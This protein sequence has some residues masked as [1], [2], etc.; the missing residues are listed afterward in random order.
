[1]ENIITLLSDAGRILSNALFLMSKNRRALLLPYFKPAVTKKVAE[2]TVI[3]E[4]LY[5]KYFG[6][7]L[8]KAQKIAKQAK[9][10]ITENNKNNNNNNNNNNNKYNN[11]NSNNR[12]GYK[13]PNSP[14][15]RRPFRRQRYH[16]YGKRQQY[17][18]RRQR[19]DGHSKQ[20]KS[21]RRR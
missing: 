9:I 3:E 1:M 6:D 20:N 17:N 4:Y 5:S 21:G 16:K 8:D 11:N 7:E 14:N 13:N 12:Q 19:Q 10:I 2:S 18:Q 15:F